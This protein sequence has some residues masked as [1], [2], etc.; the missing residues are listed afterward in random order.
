MIGCN[1]LMWE[2]QLHCQISLQ[3]AAEELFDSVDERLAPK[4]FML[5]VKVDK[6]QPGPFVNLECNGCEYNVAT[7]SSLEAVPLKFLGITIQEGSFSLENAYSNVLIAG[8]YSELQRIL[9]KHSKNSLVESFISPPAFIN[10]Y[11]VFVITELNRSIMNTFYSLTKSNF[12]AFPGLEV[13]RSFM[14]S[15]VKIYLHASTNALKA[16]SQSEF[17]ILSKSRDELVRKAAQDFMITVARAGG[18]P[19]SLQIL[20][21][22]CNTISSLKYEGEEGLGKMIIAAPNHANVSLTMELEEPIHIND[23]RKVRKFLE[24]ADSKHLL[25]SDSV[26]I[27]GLGKLVGKYN[28]HDESL[29]IIH[30]TKHFHWEVVHHG[31]IMISVSFRMPALYNEQINKQKFTTTLSRIFKALKIERINKLWSITAEAT[32]QKHGTIL[33][34]TSSAE[35]EAVRLSKQSF[36]IKQMSLNK[37]IIQQIT[38]IDGAVLMDTNCNCFAIGVILD[39]IASTLG[40]SSR[41]ARYNSALRY[42]EFMEEKAGIVL[43]VI[44]EDGMI[45]LIPD[46]KPQIRHSVVLGKIEEFKTL[47]LIESKDRRRFN[48]LMEYFEQN[49]FYFNSNEC[50][51]LNSLKAEIEQKYRFIDG[52]KM[53]YDKFEPNVKMNDSYYLQ[54]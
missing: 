14:E 8:F 40:D 43:I 32:K 2:Q 21:D 39:G 9:R 49:S 19:S 1:N 3:F 34:V 10:G 51:T 42:F 41:G 15:I 52:V 29:F 36:K 24:L 53:I 26:F 18:N 35:M 12:N 13:S 4:V 25:I 16:K 23:F 54:E 31:K 47:K 50:E 11:L 7:F 30:F 17:N 44:S 48:L 38:S 28:H 37:D 45:N 46:L 22:A 27:Y 33:V 6:K 20:Y 5:G